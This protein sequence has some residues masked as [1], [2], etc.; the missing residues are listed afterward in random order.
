V[1]HSAVSYASQKQHVEK[2]AF[3]QSLSVWCSCWE[4]VER[5]STLH[6]PES[7]LS[8]LGI[9]NCFPNLK[10][11]DAGVSQGPAIILNTSVATSSLS[12]RFDYALTF[13]NPRRVSP[14]ASFSPFLS[15][16]CQPA[17]TRGVGQ[18]SGLTFP[19]DL[20]VLGGDLCPSLIVP[21]ATLLIRLTRSRSPTDTHLPALARIRDHRPC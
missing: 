20:Q 6:Q 7:C 17:S 5:S 1:S 9:F 16:S 14:F 4:A 12:P 18:E 21:T 3:L 2:I 8:R 19:S 15:S 10:F 13:D 11:L